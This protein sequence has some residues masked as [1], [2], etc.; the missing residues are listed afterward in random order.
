MCRDQPSKYL[1]STLI[2]AMQQLEPHG[3]IELAKMKKIWRRVL[4]AP[5]I[6]ARK[7]WKSQL[8]LQLFHRHSQNLLHLS[9]ANIRKEPLISLVSICLMIVI[10]TMETTPTGRGRHRHHKGQHHLDKEFINRIHYSI[11]NLGRWEG[12]AVAFVL[13]K[14]F[15]SSV[16]RFPFDWLATLY[17]FTCFPRINILSHSPNYFY[18]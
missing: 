8:T 13:G 10:T 2:L 7:Q 11:M 4:A 18:T 14:I 12:R 9:T 17:Y 6:S 15:Q 5:I 3:K 16:I 1:P